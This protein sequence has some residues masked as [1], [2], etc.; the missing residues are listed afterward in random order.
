MSLHSDDDDDDRSPDE[1]E[2]E[3]EEQEDLF[4]RGHENV[5]LTDDPNL[6]I[7]SQSGF[8]N[9]DDAEPIEARPPNEI[10][11]DEQERHQSG[12]P[13]FRT[14]EDVRQIITKKRID[15][16]LRCFSYSKKDVYQE[17]KWRC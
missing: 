9:Y 12:T 4:N 11:A 14:L 15:H 6:Q 7:A 2:E 10:D 17:H 3:E 5:F 16:F 8:E 13:A 1:D